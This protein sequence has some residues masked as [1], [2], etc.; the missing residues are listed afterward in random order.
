MV[1]GDTT[2]PVTDMVKTALFN[3]LGEDVFDSSWLDLFGGTGSIGLEALSRGAAHAF[4]LEKNRAA[5]FRAVQ[6]FLDEG[7]E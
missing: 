2:R 5:L 7:I 6:A 1:P 3:I 4:F